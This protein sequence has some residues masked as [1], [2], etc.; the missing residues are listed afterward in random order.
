MPNPPSKRAK[1]RLVRQPMSARVRGALPRQVRLY[2]V[3]EPRM[4]VEELR[5]APHVLGEQ[6]VYRV[7]FQQAR[8]RGALLTLTR[9]RHGGSS[10][11]WR[12]TSAGSRASTTRC[13]RCT[14]GAGSRRGTSRRSSRPASVAGRPSAIGRSGVGS[15]LVSLSCLIA[16][17][18]GSGPGCGQSHAEAVADSVRKYGRGPFLVRRTGD[19]A[20]VLTAP[21]LNLRVE[22]KDQPGGPI[23]APAERRRRMANA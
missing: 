16:A 3:G 20:M 21:T 7:P 14:H 2:P 5:H 19:E 1:H 15:L 10:L 12:S 6:V 9:D 23:P 22:A 8:L 18:S 13:S 4:L 17:P 11:W